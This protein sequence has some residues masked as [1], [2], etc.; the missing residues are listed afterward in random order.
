MNVDV[1]DGS[2]FSFCSQAVIK[3]KILFT[4][5]VILEL[6]HPALWPHL[7]DH[8]TQ[9]VVP[10]PAEWSWPTPHPSSSFHLCQ[11]ISSYFLFIMAAHF[12]I[13]DALK[14]ITTSILLRN[15]N[16]GMT[17]TLLGVKSYENV[18]TDIKTF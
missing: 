18:L 16:V 11:M 9:C 3:L 5:N 1:Y 14:L 15:C 13:C 7:P 2:V 10:P 6:S 12:Y 8:C 17:L 4:M